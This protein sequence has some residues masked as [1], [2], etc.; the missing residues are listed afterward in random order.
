[1]ALGENIARLRKDR[2]WTQAILADKM[3]VN[4]NHVSRWECN[5][6]RPSSRTIKRLAE[7]FGVSVDDLLSTQKP[8]P[9]LLTQDEALRDGYLQMLELSPEDRALVLRVIETFATRKRM[10]RLLGG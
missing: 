8:P 1:M 5:R 3:N 2:S 9:D 7:A 10:E 6:Q 4:A